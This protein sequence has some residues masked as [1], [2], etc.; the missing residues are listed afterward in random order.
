VLD[1]VFMLFNTAAMEVCAVAA[2]TRRE[3]KII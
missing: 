1:T 3:A 2:A